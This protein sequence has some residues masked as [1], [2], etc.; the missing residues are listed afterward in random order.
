[1]YFECGKVTLEEIVEEI[2]EELAESVDSYCPREYLDCGKATPEEIGD[3]IAETLENYCSR[4]YCEY[5]SAALEEI[6]DDYSEAICAVPM[7]RSHNGTPL[8][9]ALNVSLQ[10]LT[11]LS[12]EASPVDSPTR[13]G[14]NL[15]ESLATSDFSITPPEEADD[16]Q[17]QSDMVFAEILTRTSRSSSLMALPELLPASLL[18]DSSMEPL[19]KRLGETSNG[20]QMDRSTDVSE[21][22]E[23]DVISDNLA[24]QAL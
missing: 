20:H 23:S 1:D 12:A 24:T 2:D 13:S 5:A 18:T 11:I 6:R 14:A 9:S 19:L 17:Q 10:S 15:V 8:G 21:V 22:R 16:L 4:E 3:E 7:I